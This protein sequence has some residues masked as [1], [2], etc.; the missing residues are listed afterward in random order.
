MRAARADPARGPPTRPR[1]P[2]RPPLSLGWAMRLVPARRCVARAQPPRRPGP[3]PGKLLACPH[4]RS[5]RHGDRRARRCRKPPTEHSDSGG[6]SARLWPQCPAG[7]P[8]EHARPPSR[9]PW[10][11]AAPAGCS[12]S[13]CRVAHHWQ[14]GLRSVHHPSAPI[15]PALG[16]ARLPMNSRNCAPKP[17]KG[18]DRCPQGGA[19]SSS[20][21]RDIPFNGR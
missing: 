17:P 13:G 7:L 21:P 1:P 2:P 18:S 10:R 19:F 5:H 4:A 3:G 14:R 9:E 15:E 20:R 12:R 6:E 11:A 8:T 16:P